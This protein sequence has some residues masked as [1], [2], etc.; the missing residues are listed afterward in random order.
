[1][2]KVSILVPFEGIV[3]GFSVMFSVV[4][5]KPYRKTLIILSSSGDYLL[6]YANSAQNEFQFTHINAE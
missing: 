6:A 5:L 1:L 3:L 4:F 2:V